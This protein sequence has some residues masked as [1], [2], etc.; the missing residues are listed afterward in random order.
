MAQSFRG[1][2]Y[3]LVAALS[4]IFSLLVIVFDFFPSFGIS[5][6][7]IILALF[8]YAHVKKNSETRLFLT[9]CLIFSSFLF[10]RS[11][12][13]VSFFNFWAAVFFGIL[14]LTSSGKRSRGFVGYFFLPISLFFETLFVQSEYYPEF[15]KKIKKAEVGGVVFGV[16]VSLLV[17][18]VILPLLASANPIFENVLRR[19]A[20]IFNLEGLMKKIGPET[21]LLWCL[22]LLF[23]G[24][25]LFMIPKVLTVVEKEAEYVL[26][27]VFRPRSFPLQIPKAAT[28][29]VLAIFFVTQIQLYFA[30]EQALLE[31]GVNYSQR[32]REVFGQLSVVEVI[33]FLLVYNSEPGKQL[34]KKLNWLLGIEG[35]FLNLMAYKS[36]FEYIDAHGLTYKRLD[37]IVFATLVAGVF[38]LYKNDLKNTANDFARRVIVF[39]ALALVTVNVV[40]FDFLIY[41]FNRPRISGKVDYRYLST[42]SADSLSYDEQFKMLEEATFDEDFDGNYHNENPFILLYKIESLQK[43]YAEFDL[44][45]FN[46]LDYVQYRGIRE[47]ETA[48]LRSH[49]EENLL[50]RVNRE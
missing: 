29:V 6:S 1:R 30:K 4:F 46:L 20:E 31:L 2:T 48:R 18:A 11:E 40:N 41:R 50:T 37:G 34:A 17:L 43:K 32:A 47:L 42:L 35:I 8:T 21:V 9:F 16:A 25:F 14:M 45:E 12:P 13:V 26:P 33:V 49:Y 24:G 10:I 7:L 15:N 22:R 5:L 36:V 27:P 3:F 19:V 44:R 28:A 23:F 39:F 38:V